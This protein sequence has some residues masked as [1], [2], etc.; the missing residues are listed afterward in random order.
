LF[1]LA[2]QAALPGTIGWL[3]LMLLAL[4]NL[5][6][7]VFNLLPALPL[8][9]GRVLR[10]GVWRAS[11]NRRAGTTAAVTGGYL[12]AVG[13]AAWG[14]ALLFDGGT[15]ALLPASLAVL[16]ALFVVIG[17]A[18]EKAPSDGSVRHPT[19]VSFTSLIRP[20][21]NLPSA[22]PVRVALQAAAQREVILTGSDGVA[23]GLLDVRAARLLADR[24]PEAPASL[25]AHPLSPYAIVLADDDPAEV[26]DRI[27]AGADS[28]FVL[29]DAAGRPAGVLRKQDLPAEPGASRPRGWRR[30]R[31]G[32]TEAPPAPTTGPHWENLHRRN[33]HTGN[34]HTENPYGEN[35]Y[36]E[37]PYGENPYG[38]N[39]YGENPY[40][41]Q[42]A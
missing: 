13:L 37:N 18:A 40:G 1:W 15:A 32:S 29:V 41:E 10:A 39:P 3:L 42:Q 34:P 9:G 6:V 2:A 21:T 28:A 16:M 11:G 4:S 25:V 12:V 5:L 23:R 30:L 14:A 31:R 35:P 24:D 22:T 7:T 38:E 19:A 20:L 17:A 36:G 27:R 8:D 26:T 33:P